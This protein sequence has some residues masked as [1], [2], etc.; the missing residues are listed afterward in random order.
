MSARDIAFGANQKRGLADLWFGTAY[1]SVPHARVEAKAAGADIA[2]ADTRIDTAVVQH[3]K[4]V[5]VHY[6]VSTGSISAANEQVGGFSMAMRMVDIDA[7]SLAD[8][9]T[10]WKRKTSR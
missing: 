1:A 9:A 4:L 10:S 3:G 5:D 6:K 2:F 7:K 8:T